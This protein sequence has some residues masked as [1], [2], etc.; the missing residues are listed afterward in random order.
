[1]KKFIQTNIKRPE[2]AVKKGIKGTS[3]ITFI[4]EPDGSVTNGKVLKGIPGG[5][6]LDDEA[7]RVV[8]LMPK[9]NPGK[10]DGKFVRVA[11]CL[12]IKFS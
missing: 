8:K 1:M 12:P 9:W 7:L 4:V 3:Y 10:Q 2:E 5:Q 11:F 6:I